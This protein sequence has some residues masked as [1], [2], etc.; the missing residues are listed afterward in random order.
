MDFALS[1]TSTLIRNFLIK[2]LNKYHSSSTVFARLS[3]LWLFPIS[4]LKLPLRGKCFEST[5]AESKRNFIGRA[6]GFIGL[7]Q[8]CKAVRRKQ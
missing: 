7:S 5:E 6:E 2:N 8:K 1:H 4:K 3:C